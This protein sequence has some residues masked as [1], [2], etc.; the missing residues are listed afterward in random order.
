MERE[1][2]PELIPEIRFG[3]GES[4]QILYF[5]T[6]VKCPVSGVWGWEINGPGIHRLWLGVGPKSVKAILEGLQKA[7]EAG[8]VAHDG[9]LA[10]VPTSENE[11]AV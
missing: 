1:S 2:L 6:R 3:F 8:K 10:S 9:S 7:Y 4:N 5:A 11:S